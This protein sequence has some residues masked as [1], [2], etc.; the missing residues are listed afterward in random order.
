M[1]LINSFLVF[2]L[3]LGISCKNKNANSESD[4]F[5]TENEPTTFF[6]HKV[7]GKFTIEVPGYLKETQNL[8]EDADLQFINLPNGILT[9]IISEKLND[10]IFTDMENEIELPETDADTSNLNFYIHFQIQALKEQF[11]DYGQIKVMDTTINGIRSKKIRVNATDKTTG[12]RYVVWGTAL[13]S[14]DRYFYLYQ[15]TPLTSILKFEKDME[16]TVGSF[17]LID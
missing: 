6:K 2:M 7:D 3:F 4:D 16:K 5:K 1:K 13:N 8:N 15:V 17:K 10:G 14:Q 9:T 12:E 11:T